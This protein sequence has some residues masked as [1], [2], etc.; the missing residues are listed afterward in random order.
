MNRHTGAD[1]AEPTSSP[2]LVSLRTEDV[3]EIVD[4]VTRLFGHHKIISMAR[5]RQAGSVIAKR[6]HGLIV[7]ELHYGGAVLLDVD[8]R[9][10]GWVITHAQGGAGTLSGGRFGAGDMLMFPPHWCGDLRLDLPTRLRNAF[11]PTE[12]MHLAMENLLGSALDEPLTFSHRLAP[13]S[14]PAVRLGNIIDFMYTAG[15]LPASVAQM[16][17]QAWKQTFTMELLTLWPHSYSRHLDRARLLPRSLRR[18]CE[19]IDAHV[20]EPISVVDAARA[21]SVGVRALEMGFARHFGQSPLHYIRDRRLDAARQ[22]LCVG[23][24]R[25]RV[26]DVALKWGFSNAGFFAKAYRERFGELPSQSV[27][28][29]PR[30]SHLRR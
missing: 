16:L 25:P 21:A 17:Q 12:E 18:A 8:E 4:M 7:G 10:P 23:H 22:D 27:S 3:D 26:A 29:A 19:Y 5:S 13:S 30:A 20:G 15:A 28:A 14:S 1:P 9:R 11:V 24:A 6:F 2:T